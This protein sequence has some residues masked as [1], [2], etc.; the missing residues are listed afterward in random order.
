MSKK[1]TM[2]FIPIVANM[3][4]YSK[5]VGMK[6]PEV[7]LL[8]CRRQLGL[9]SGCQSF[10]RANKASIPLYLCLGSNTKEEVGVESIW[11]FGSLQNQLMSAK[12]NPK[13]VP[14]IFVVSYIPW[15]TLWRNGEEREKK[16]LIIFFFPFLFHC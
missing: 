9:R 10:T 16:T 11:L 4:L 12:H 7:K 14:L 6:E 3:A 15:G 13:S 5:M 2:S 1:K 8:Y